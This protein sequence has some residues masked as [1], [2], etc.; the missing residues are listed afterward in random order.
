M[1]SVTRQKRR[2]RAAHGAYPP[3]ENVEAR[4]NDRLWWAVPFRNARK[5]AP[6]PARSRIGA[7]TTWVVIDCIGFTRQ[8]QQRLFLRVRRKHR[9]RPQDLCPRTRV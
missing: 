3:R 9:H 8:H 7:L 1:S 2:G 6:N 4:K 5:R